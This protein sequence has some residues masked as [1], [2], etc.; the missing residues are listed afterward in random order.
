MNKL[1]KCAVGICFFVFSVERVEAQTLHAILIGDV[2]PSTGFGKYTSAVKN[3]LIGV[4]IALEENMPKSLL[5]VV[6]FEC[7]EDIDSSPKNILKAIADLN[8]T[9]NDSILL[10]YT[11]HGAVDDQGPYL[12]LAQGKLYRQEVLKRLTAKGSRFSGVHF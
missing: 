7:Q 4:A 1:L 10:Y 3:D 12:A 8:V 6:Q 5:N 9:S 2:S 11:G